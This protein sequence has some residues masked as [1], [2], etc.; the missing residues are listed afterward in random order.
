MCTLRKLKNMKNSKGFSLLEMAAVLMIAGL[1]I[2]PAITLYHQNQ[3]EEDWEQTED[4][5][6]TVLSAIGGFRAVYGRYP[7]PAEMTAAPGDNEYGHESD[8]N[9]TPGDGNCVDGICESDSVLLG[10][11]VIKGSIPFKTLNILESQSYDKYNNRLTYAVTKDMA[12]ANSFTLSGGGITVQDKVGNHLIDPP[13]TAHFIVI[14]HG[15]NQSGGF[16]KSGL[17]KVACNDSSIEEQ[18]NCDNDSAFISGE[19]DDVYDDRTD[20]FSAVNLSEWQRSEALG[21]EETIHLKNT[22]SIAVGAS[23]TTNLNDA[24]QT[25]VRSISSDSGGV[26]AELSFHLEKICEYGATTDGEC[27]TPGL[28]AGQLSPVSVGGD[29]IFEKTND[30]GISCYDSANPATGPKRYMVGIEDG[31][32]ICEDEIFL[33]CPNGGVITGINA[34]GEII[35]GTAPAKSCPQTD[36]VSACGDTHTIGDLPTTLSGNVALTYSGECRL[37]TDYDEEYFATALAGKSHGQIYNHVNNQLNSEDRTI[38]DCGPDEDYAQIRETY[39]C[40]DSVWTKRRTHEK[41]YP[42]QSF[43]SNPLSSGGSQAA[44]TNGNAHP[45]NNNNRYNHDCWCREDYRVFAQNCPGGLSGYQ[46]VVQ[47]HRCPQ[48]YHR[49]QTI[50]TQ[51]EQCACV[52]STTTEHQSCNS[53][54]D[55]VNGTSGTTGLSGNVA[56]TYDITCQDG[57]PVQGTTPTSIDTSDCACAQNSDAIRRVS[58]PAGTGNS[59]SWSGGNE[60]NVAELYTQEWTCPGTTSGGL[61]DPGSL[62]AEQAQTGIPSCSCEVQ[63]D[64]VVTACPAGETGTGLKRERRSICPSVSGNVEWEP[65]EDWTVIENDCHTCAWQPPAGSPSLEEYPYGSEK[66]GTCTCGSPAA[67]QCYDYAAG[68]KYDVWSGCQCVGQLD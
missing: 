37:I 28:I 52:A 41:G 63:T 30:E 14:S 1:I 32:A 59:W 62:A 57:A 49:W 18:E 61:P 60:T 15:Q 9:A 6:D 17:E 19:I 53:Y 36:V 47:K 64:I 48:T 39:Q 24:S 68:G 43:P 45:D 4:N 2:T 67:E 40:N 58:C 35:C 7:C 38:V 12:S 26:R 42:W 46:Y 55:E 29:T 31:E 33:S 34:D 23:G 10:Q 8:C 25:E 11:S 56:L 22:D 5:V 20:Y 66:G 44:E 21:F 13:N 16:T 54:Y 51:T 27:F 50:Y 65:E 3:I